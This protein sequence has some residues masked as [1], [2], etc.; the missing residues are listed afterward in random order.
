M[1]VFNMASV[2]FTDVNPYINQRIGW[3]TTGLQ[4]PVSIFQN[5]YTICQQKLIRNML[6]RMYGLACTKE[7]N[8]SYITIPM[9]MGCAW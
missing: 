2:I 3:P 7:Q 6:D 8:M 1:N 9:G 5:T 4:I